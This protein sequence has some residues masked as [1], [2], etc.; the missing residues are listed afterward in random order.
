MCV[1]TVFELIAHDE[2]LERILDF[3]AG[4]G[5]IGARLASRGLTNL[6]GHDGSQSKKASL[7]KKGDY[8]EVI[9]FIV[10]K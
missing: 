3:G 2:D 7:M 4:K 1:N 10:G 5:D 9:T 8:R 6:Y